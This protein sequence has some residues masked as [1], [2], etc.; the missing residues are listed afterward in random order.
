MASEWGSVFPQVAVWVMGI[1]L[2][3]A[4]PQTLRA[5]APQGAVFQDPLDVPAPVGPA[6]LTTRIFSVVNQTGRLFAVGAHGTI[7]ASADQGKRWEQIPSPVA[8]DLTAIAFATANDGVIVG[9]DSLLLR[10]RDGGRT[11]IRQFDVR[12]LNQAM[13]DHYR[14]LDADPGDADRAVIR[15][16][17]GELEQ[18]VASGSPLPFFDVWFADARLGFAVGAFNLLL[19]TEDGGE[20]WVPWME[21]TENPRGAHLY[22]VRGNPGTDGDVYIAG[23]LGLL[24]RLDRKARRFVA[25]PTPYDGTYFAMAVEGD[26]LVVAGLRGNALLSRDR[27]R[28]WTRIATGT[29]A[30]IAAVARID[31]TRTDGGGFA[32]LTQGGGVLAID[33]SGG[34]VPL[35]APL[36]RP[37][38]ALAVTG[39]GSVAVGTDIGV[40]P[41]TLS[42]SP[43]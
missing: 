12:T 22:A 40:K 8:S 32:L 18:R 15:Q 3:T 43:R 39:G 23:E 28:D 26:T 29:T 38:Y 30:S 37:S 1:A 19:A 10:T 5:A 27:G 20:S 25:V 9:H 2:A 24:M 11:W 35:V 14:R 42:A 31:G 13:L 34:A 21:R 4:F 7:L 6:S 16:W 17:I 33:G 36:G 41:V